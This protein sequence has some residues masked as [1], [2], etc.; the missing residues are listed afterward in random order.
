MKKLISI[1][2]IGFIMTGLTACSG[3]EFDTASIAE[4]SGRIEEFSKSIGEIQEYVGEIQQSVQEGIDNTNAALEWYNTEAWAGN[5]YISSPISANQVEN[6]IEIG[7]EE[8]SK[9]IDDNAVYD[10]LSDED[11]EFFETYFNSPS[12][13]GFLLTTYES[14]QDCDMTKVLSYSD[15]YEPIDSTEVRARNGR[16][17]GKVT[18]A[19]FERIVKE[20]LGINADDLKNVVNYRVLSGKKYMYIKEALDKPTGLVCNGGFYYNDVYLLMMASKDNA[21]SFAFTLLRKQDDDVVISMN[22]WSEDM[23][24]V[25]WD[26]SLV[27]KLYDLMLESELP[28]L[29][30]VPGTF[31]DLSLGAEYKGSLNT[32]ELLSKNDFDAST[33]VKQYDGYEVYFSNVDP[34]DAKKALDDYVVSQIVVTDGDY[35]TN[36]G[37]G[38]GSKLEDIIKAYGKGDEMRLS[39][40]RKQ[41]TYENEKYGII[42]TIDSDDSVIEMNIYLDGAIN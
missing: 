3:A 32:A 1:I 12:K 20:N 15:E 36:E 8:A 24:A 14:P 29:I 30:S 25:E 26:G 22:Y 4:M 5:P 33:Y 39:G 31:G 2:I 19:R 35:K 38:I 16:Y 41:I 17:I 23:G 28:G 7:E 18:Q 42:F 10:A 13:M 34:D 27:Y 11:I 9:Y 40:G 6:L 21:D 37:I